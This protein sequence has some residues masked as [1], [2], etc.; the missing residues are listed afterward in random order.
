VHVPCA[1]LCDWMLQ[2]Y[3]NLLPNFPGKWRVIDAL[4]PWAQSTWARPRLVLRHGITYEL[5][6]RDLIQRYIYY[7]GEWETLET[8]F[9]RRIVKPGWTIADVGANVGYYA[10]LFSY[11]VG[12]E[13]CVF[14]F[15]LA[16]SNYESL[17]RNIGLNKAANICPY[18]IGLADVC[19]DE[20]LVPGTR[21]NSGKTRLACSSES[22]N[23]DTVRLTTLDLFV[24]EHG[25][26]HLELIKVDIEG[27]EFRFLDGAAR[28]LCRFHP[29]VVVELNPEMLSLF[30]S[31]AE[32]VV[33][34]LKEIGYSLYRMSWLG[35][36]PL[37]TLPKVGQYFNVVALPPSRNYQNL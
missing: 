20:F 36:E 23:G 27:S 15:E 7:L 30:G 16:E 17:K 9:I 35:L 19:G 26:D 25:V 31:K 18:R 12:L 22:A 34:A 33:H 13:G 8:R 21:G 5:D 4:S 29:I 24:Q 14:A 10:L 37:G 2:K 11:L 28:T 6:L 32:N 3:G 1:H